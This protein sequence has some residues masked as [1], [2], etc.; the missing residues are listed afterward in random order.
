MDDDGANIF[1]HI[2]NINSET[3]AVKGVAALAIDGVAL[4]VHHVVI[5]QQTLTD[6][7]V[8][9]LHLF[10]RPFDGLGNHAVLD[11]F[12]VLQADSVHHIGYFFGAE[13][14]HQFVFEG[15][16]EL[17]AA[18]VA[19]TA[20]TTAQLAVNA[21]GVVAFG[22]DD[23]QTALLLHA[24]SQLDIGTTTGHVGGNRD[25]SRLTGFGNDVSLLLVQLGIQYVVL[26]MTAGQNRGKQLGCLHIGRANQNRTSLFVQFQNLVHHCRILF[27]LGLINQILRIDSCNRTVGWNHNHIQFIDVPELAGLGFGGTRHTGQ[28]LVHSEIILQ[29][30]GGIGLRGGFHLHILLRLN[31]LMQ[32][33]RIT[34]PFHNTT[35]LFI[36]DFHFIVDDDVFHILL[37]HRISFQQLLNS[38]D[39]LGSDG[40]LAVDVRLA[41]GLFLRVEIFV[42]ELTDLATDIGQDEQLRLVGGSGNSLDTLFHNVDGVQLLLND[43]VQTIFAES[44]FL[45][46]NQTA[47]I[48]LRFN[49]LDAFQH[50]FVGMF[51]FQF[52][53]VTI[54]DA[55]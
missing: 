14:A 52:L 3:V 42:L 33:V 7:E 20:G 15:D 50:L 30:D 55:A 26:D 53:R 4:R 28:L 12:A 9:L 34:A 49:C 39:A 32:S 44:D 1:Q 10:L 48:E 35:C 45:E 18:R 51:E 25:G 2:G 23:G 13:E 31:G 24:G 21:A 27:T 47:V 38:V 16:V 8:V 5:L 11:H 43:E 46:L 54:G 36:N 22:A 6:A 29:G 41:D 40:E 17:G 37:E 19:L